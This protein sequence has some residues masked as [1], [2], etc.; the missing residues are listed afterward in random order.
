MED[1]TVVERHWSRAR[2]APW[3]CVWLSGVS[4]RYSAGC[5][6]S[7]STCFDACR[8]RGDLAWFVRGCFAAVDRGSADA[9]TSTVSREVGRNGGYGRYRA[10]VADTRSWAQARRPKSCKLAKYQRLQRVVARKLQADWSPEQIAGWLKQ[11]FMD[12]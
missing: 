12:D 6:L 5:A 1:W 2:E 3:L 11:K 10:A 4:R 7:Q 9:A 8:A